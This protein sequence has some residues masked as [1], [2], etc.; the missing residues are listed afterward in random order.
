MQI[1]EYMPNGVDLKTYILETLAY[2]SIPSQEPKFKQL[3]EAMGRWVRSFHDQASHQPTL[4]QEVAKNKEAQQVQQL[5]NYQFAVERLQ[6]FPSILTEALPILED[7]QKSA[8][9]ELTKEPLQ[10]IHGDLGPAK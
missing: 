1:H 9:M 10:V 5:I 8:A 6:Q 2:P 4:V 3:G 7:V